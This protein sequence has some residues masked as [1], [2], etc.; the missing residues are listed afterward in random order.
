MLRTILQCKNKFDFFTN[1]DSEG[2]VLVL[3]LNGGNIIGLNRKVRC[4]DAVKNGTP[5]NFNT[6]QLDIKL[7]AEAVKKKYPSIIFAVIEC[8]ELTAY[9]DT[10]GNAMKLDVIDLVKLANSMVNLNCDHNFT[11]KEKEH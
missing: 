7:V 2:K 5:V 3:G 8:T 4:F 1:G 9:S 11:Q 10:I 6:V